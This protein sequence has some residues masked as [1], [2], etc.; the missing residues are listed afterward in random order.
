M[1][2]QKNNI[3]YTLTVRVVACDEVRTLRLTPMIFHGTSPQGKQSSTTA[4]AE[5][6]TKK[7]PEKAIEIGPEKSQQKR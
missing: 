5:V 3:F 2:M 1:C 6:Q 4:V 7:N